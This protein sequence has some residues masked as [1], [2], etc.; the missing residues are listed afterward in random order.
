MTQAGRPSCLYPGTQRLPELWFLSQNS[1]DIVKSCIGFFKSLEVCIN[2]T[3]RPIKIF[4]AAMLSGTNK[5]EE[6]SE[7]KTIISRLGEMLIHMSSI[8]T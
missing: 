4:K 1:P 8:A 5:Y 7:Q 3:P 6:K 2:Y